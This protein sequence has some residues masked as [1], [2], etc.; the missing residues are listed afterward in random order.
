M[1]S[2]SDDVVLHVV[3]ACCIRSMTSVRSRLAPAAILPAPAAI[4]GLRGFFK[5]G[6]VS[7]SRERFQF[8]QLNAFSIL[9][10]SL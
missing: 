4:R 9:L 8:I 1:C 3:E 7:G 5:E 10:S 2:V 6:G